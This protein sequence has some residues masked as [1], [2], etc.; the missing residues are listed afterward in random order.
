[1]QTKCSNHVMQ[2]KCSN[3]V[4]QTKCS[5]HVTLSYVEGSPQS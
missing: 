5:N 4:M 1:M 3:H 2:T